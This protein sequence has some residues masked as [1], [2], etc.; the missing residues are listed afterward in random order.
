MV[1]GTIAVRGHDD[2]T[3][4]AP[5]AHFAGSRR[6]VSAFDP[7]GL[8]SA[9]RSSGPRASWRSSFRPA[10]VDFLFP[11][12]FHRRELLIYKLAQDALWRWSFMALSFRCRCLIYF[13]S[14]LSAFVGILLTLD[15]RA[16]GRP[17]D[18]ACQADRGRIRL[19]PRAQADLDWQ[20]AVLVAGG[21]G[22][23]ARG[24]PRC[25][26]SPSWLA[27]FARPGRGW[28]SWRPS[29]C[30]ATRSWPRRL[31]SR[32][33]L[34][35]RGAAAIDLG[36]L[37]P[38]PQAGHGL[39][40]GG[41]GGQPEALRTRAASAA[42]G[43]VALPSSK[44]AARAPRAAVPLDRRRR[45]ARVAAVAFGHAHIPVLLICLLW[46]SAVMFARG[47][48]RPGAGR[49]GQPELVPVDGHRDSWRT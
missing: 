14:W 23:D 20:L 49:P 8:L 45:A 34:L 41:G 6:T 30:S 2:A 16:T 10:E 38:D 32:S 44:N 47:G 15:V 40:R 21:A 11:A 22:P 13:Q 37:A 28:C 29:R 24:R 33:G 19:Y 35:G 31:V 3:R 5:A 12:P 27:I 25:R 18:G 46:A 36:L 43:R 4:S 39:P 9:D 7:S 48:V 42:R 26:A 17:G 1:A